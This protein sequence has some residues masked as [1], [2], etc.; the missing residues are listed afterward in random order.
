MIL[1]VSLACAALLWYNRKTIAKVKPALEV[2][3]IV[4]VSPAIIATIVLWQL[5]N[6]H[7]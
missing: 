5:A 1:I 6:N 7:E 2:F 3:F 4:L